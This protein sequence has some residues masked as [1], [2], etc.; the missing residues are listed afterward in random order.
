M[1]TKTDLKTD[2]SAVFESSRFVTTERKNSPRTELALPICISISLLRFSTLVN[3]IPGT[4]ILHLLWWIAAY[5]QRTLRWVSREIKYFVFLVLIFIPARAHAAENR[6][7]PC[8]KAWRKDASSSK[9]PAIIGGWSC[10]SHLWHPLRLG[11]DYLSNPCSN[12]ED[13]EEE[14]WQHTPLSESNTNGERLWFKSPDT[15]INFWAGIHWLDGKYNKWPLTP[16]SRSTSRSF[17]RGTWSYTLEVDKACVDQT[18]F[19][20]FQGFL[21]I[22][23]KWKFELQCYGRDENQSH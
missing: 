8:W 23:C 4:W 2:S 16:Y 15:D 12:R 10:S 9:S 5:M 11:C 14:W 1:G 13:N 17:S 21:K 19:V 20:C 3:T 6:W 22:C 18:C 7:S